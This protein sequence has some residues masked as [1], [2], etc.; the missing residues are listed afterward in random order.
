MKTMTILKRPII[1]EK[2]LSLASRGWY[3]FEVSSLATKPQ[4]AR[5]IAD[6][7]KVNVLSVSTL[8]VKGKTRRVGKMR[9]EIE[10]G[11]SKKAIVRIGKDQKIA[12]FETAQ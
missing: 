5:A 10:S 7:F 12:L 9:K 8:N 1:T 11:K 4:V 2:T 3:T 6:Q